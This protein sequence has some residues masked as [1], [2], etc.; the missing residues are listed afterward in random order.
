M[1][2]WISCSICLAIRLPAFACPFGL[3]NSTVKTVKYLVAPFA[4][5]VSAALAFA[6]A[7]ATASSHSPFR[8]RPSRP[9]KL[10]PR[11]RIRCRPP[12]GRAVT[13][14]APARGPTRRPRYLA[15]SSCCPPTA[16][17]PRRSNP[18]PIPTSR[19]NCGCRP[20][21]GT[22]SSRWSAM[23]AGPA[24]SAFR[25]WRRRCA[26]AMRPR[27]PTPATKA[28]TACSRSITRRRSS[29]VCRLQQINDWRAYRTIFQEFV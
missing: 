8:I 2:E 1:I 19:W 23:A 29:I 15:A 18:P 17:W 26:K 5:C 10:S 11:A 20:T 16:R 4:C 28:A 6:R 27:P 22:G 13:F 3:R 12:S 9:L 7:L 14:R 21:I 24:L 25:R